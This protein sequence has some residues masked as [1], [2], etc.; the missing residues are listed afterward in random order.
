MDVLIITLFVQAGLLVS[1]YFWLAYL[2]VSC[3]WRATLTYLA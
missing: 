2:V 3:A 1:D